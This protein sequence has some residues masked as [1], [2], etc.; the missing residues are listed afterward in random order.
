M[1]VS[2]E[3][4]ILISGW[5]FSGPEWVDS[6]GTGKFAFERGRFVRIDSDYSID[7]A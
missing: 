6:L 7:D 1:A 2:A 4:P 3:K 5:V